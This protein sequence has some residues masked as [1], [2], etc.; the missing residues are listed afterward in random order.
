MKLITNNRKWGTRRERMVGV[1]DLVDAMNGKEADMA[2][3]DE[4]LTE[5]YQDHIVKEIK[6]FIDG[7]PKE[8]YREARKGQRYAHHIL[9]YPTGE[10]RFSRKGKIFRQAIGEVLSE[11]EKI[12]P[13]CLAMEQRR[14]VIGSIAVPTST[15]DK[16]I[17]AYGDNIEIVY[18]VTEPKPAPQSEPAS[19]PAP[20]PVPEA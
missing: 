5:G 16:E 18:I 7:Y 6:S 4:E 8:L 19:E 3:E 11:L 9:K 12:T 10:N 14:E 15:R 1:Q 13:N 17:S 2:Q 20:E